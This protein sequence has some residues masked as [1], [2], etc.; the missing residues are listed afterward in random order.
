MERKVRRRLF[1][2]AGAVAL[3]IAL[4]PACSSDES[5]S[6]SGDT[7][8]GDGTV[9]VTLQEFAVAADPGTAP[10]GSVTF[11]VTNVGPNDVHE[12]VVIKTDLAP[13]ELPTDETGTVLESGEGMEVID[14]IEDIPV[15][16]NETLTVDLEAGSYALIC[17]IYS[18][19]EQE[20]HYS[21]GM[22]IGFTVE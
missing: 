10:A 9:A 3:T 13:T 20:A 22:R 11:D 6:A 1:V 18:E 16:A 14:E 2:V 7:G 15:D 17:N 12:F 8:S 4:V 5:S 19:D 21:E